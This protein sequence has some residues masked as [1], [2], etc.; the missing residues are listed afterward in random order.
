[1]RP[2]SDAAGLKLSSE[3]MEMTIELVWTA[4]ALQQDMPSNSAADGDCRFDGLASVPSQTSIAWP[5]RATFCA[6][7]AS[8]NTEELLSS[9]K[10]QYCKP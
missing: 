7:D 5:L 6:N 10:E 1:M 8:L 4:L 2:R 3:F 9:H